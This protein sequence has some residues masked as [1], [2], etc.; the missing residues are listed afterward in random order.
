MTVHVVAKI[1]LNIVVVIR[2][3]FKLVRIFLENNKIRENKF[4]SLQQ[5]KTKCKI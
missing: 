1:S 4:I 5:V 3:V 2:P